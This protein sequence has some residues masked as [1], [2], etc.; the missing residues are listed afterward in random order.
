MDT[1]IKDTNEDVTD[2]IYNAI[3]DIAYISPEDIICPTEIQGEEIADILWTQDQVFQ[4][5]I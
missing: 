2:T 5:K 1:S 4:Q 3:M